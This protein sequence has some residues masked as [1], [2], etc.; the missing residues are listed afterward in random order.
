[1]MTRAPRLDAPSSV[2]VGRPPVLDDR[3]AAAAAPCAI[4][5]Q[6]I[7]RLPCARD[8]LL[9]TLD[10]ARVLLR[11]VERRLVAADVDVRRP[12]SC[13]ASLADDVVHEL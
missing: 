11:R 1:M 9:H 10:E 13:A 7:I 2:G 8:D 12:A 5:S 3:V 4:S 6:P